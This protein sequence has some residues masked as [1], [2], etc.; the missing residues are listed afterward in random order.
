MRL[1]PWFAVLFIVASLLNTTFAEN[2]RVV[3]WD[4]QQPS[5]KEAYPS[6]LGQYIADYLKRQPELVV[7]SV[8]IDHPQK[9]LS[10]EVLDNCDVLI[11]WGHVRNG[12]VSFDE[13]RPVV[14][15]IRKGQLSML[16]LHSAH[17]ATPF[18]LAMHDRAEQ[19]AL[20][21]LS[22]ELRANATTQFVGEFKRKAPKRTDRFTPT[23]SM[24][25]GN[26]SQLSL[27]LTRPNCCF[28]A[29]RN[30]GK[31]SEMTTVLT[32]HPIAA[33]IPKQFVLPHTEM[34]DEPFHVPAPDEVVFEER[35]KTGERFRSGMIWN[36]GEGKIV[37]F[38]PG[39]ETH[40]VYTEKV[41]MKI[42]ENC[43]RWLGK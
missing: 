10:D 34:Y 25:N 28:P 24:I 4:E 2:I 33:D 12:E 26:S 20:Q 41:P 35:R 3:I 42:V 29:Y 8:S 16:A 1:R 5:Q 36:F 14:D 21:M 40:A 9:G 19:D 32:A 38:R 11:W 30:D 6:F 18:V 27:K 15:R 39:H 23:V 17:W 37:Y 31:P 43:V 7:N 13:A 22:P